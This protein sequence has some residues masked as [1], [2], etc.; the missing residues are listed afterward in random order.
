MPATLNE[1]ALSR[2]PSIQ[3]GPTTIAP[4]HAAYVIA[5]AG[6]NHDGELDV[7]RELIQAAAAAEANAVK[8]QVF[9]ADRL[10][11][12]E[13]PVG[14]LPAACR[15]RVLASTRCSRDWSWS[16]ANLRSWPIMPAAAASSS[17]PPPSPRPTLEFLASIEV[18]AI[19]L[20]S[21]DIVN[22][23]LLET[24]GRCGL[25]VIAST[26]AA[27]LEEIGEGVRCLRE[28]GAAEIALLHCISSY[29]AREDEA[30]LAAIRSLA[31]EFGCVAGFS[32]HTESLDHWRAGP[33]GRRLHHR[34]TFDALSRPEGPGPLL[35]ARAAGDGR[36]HPQCT[37]GGGHAGQ[38]SHRPDARTA[39][40]PALARSSLVTA[41]PVRAGQEI[42]RAML[43]S[44]RPGG[45]ISP[46]KIEQ[47]IGRRPCKDL[48]PDT[49]L[50]WEMLL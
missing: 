10:V 19:K 34:K 15:T 5:E 9:S 8:F 44:K 31:E 23:P 48:T 7:A 2:R 11:T 50:S 12:R 42:T 3:I 33:G 25:P 39:R 14:R 49:A 13:A 37:A 22:L 41:C 29:P 46:M 35:L 40:D 20:A 43:T 1:P 30:N 26:G 24:V 28:A 6:V 27:E 47:V 45:G 16:I 21:P 4:N 17:W 18:R 38:R 32:D 36:V